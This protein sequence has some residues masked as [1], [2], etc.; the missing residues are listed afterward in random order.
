MK[1]I[2]RTKWIVKRKDTSSLHIEGIANTKTC[3]MSCTGLK[4]IM[5]SIKDIY[6][7]RNVRLMS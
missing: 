1:Q 6:R 7:S 3:N 5:Q 2:S 4:G